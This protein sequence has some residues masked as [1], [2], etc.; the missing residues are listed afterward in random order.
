MA[1]A[2][3]F[4]VLENSARGYILHVVGVDTATTTAF[5]SDGSSTG[6][7]AANGYTPT[8]SLKVRRVVYNMTNCMARLQWHQTTNAELINLSGY[9]SYDVRDNQGIINPK[10][11]GSTGDIDLTTYPIAAVTSGAGVV[12]ATMSFTLECIKGV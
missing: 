5:T 3:T 12:T 8:T 1:M 2:F 9:G 4:E 7:V 11:T 6:I 10:G